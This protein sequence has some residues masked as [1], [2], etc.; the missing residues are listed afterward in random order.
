MSHLAS[1]GGREIARRA[2][3][4]Q[5]RRAVAE[6][7]IPRRFDKTALAVLVGRAGPTAAGHTER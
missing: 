5:V 7:A 4:A 3:V 1:L 2:F 6:P